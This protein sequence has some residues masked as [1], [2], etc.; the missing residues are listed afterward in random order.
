MT[1]WAWL[2]GRFRIWL[3]K[4]EAR[5]CHAR[6][7]PG[8]RHCRYVVELIMSYLDDTLDPAERL[9]FEAHIADC[10]NCWR[11]LR[12]YRATI[13]LGQ[14]LRDEDIPSDVRERLESFLRNRLQWPS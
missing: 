5:V 13:T 10:R 11:F 9:A 6:Q 2:M 1:F 14:R 12:S 7:S 4:I 8:M 3:R